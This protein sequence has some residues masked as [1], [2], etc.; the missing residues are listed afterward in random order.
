MS[1]FDARAFPGR[2]ILTG[3]VFYGR[4]FRKDKKTEKFEEKPVMKSVTRV[5]QLS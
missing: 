1:F 4:P 3:T 5:E 2:V